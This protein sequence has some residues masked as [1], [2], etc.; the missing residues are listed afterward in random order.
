MVVES[1]MFATVFDFRNHVIFD[2]L[3]RLRLWLSAR[4][5]TMLWRYF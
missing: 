5:N 4:V 2:I 3:R 1:L